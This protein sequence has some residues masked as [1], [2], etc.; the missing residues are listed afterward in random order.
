MNELQTIGTPKTRR[1][2]DQGSVGIAI[3]GKWMAAWFNRPGFE[4]FGYRVYALAGDGCLMEGISGEAASTRC[5]SKLMQ[6][7]LSGVT[8]T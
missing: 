3:A 5:R 2:G 6:R 1:D 7:S 4:M 8:W